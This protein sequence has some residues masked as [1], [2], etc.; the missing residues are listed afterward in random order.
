M[1][2]YFKAE[3]WFARIGVG[4]WG[5][6]LESWGTTLRSR[7]SGEQIA[8]PNGAKL[9]GVRGSAM[10]VNVEL[11]IRTGV[12]MRRPEVDAGLR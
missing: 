1:G 9:L 6:R 8:V 3:F 2:L 11:E 5:G 4:S 7:G 12:I 10:I